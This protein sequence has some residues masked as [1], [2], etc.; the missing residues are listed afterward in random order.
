MKKSYVLIALAVVAALSMVGCKN[1]N[2]KAQSQEAVQEPTQEEVQKMKQAL[3][4]TV[5]AQID[6]FAEEYI[7]ASGNSFTFRGLEL[8][9][10]EKLNKPDYLLDPSV[11]NNLVTKTQKVNALA[12]YLVD[13]GVRM[14]YDMPTEEAKEAITKLAMDVNYPID[15]DH[16]QVGNNLAEVTKSHYEKCKERGELALF[17]Q[18]HNAMIKETYYI[19][20]QNPELFFSKITEEQWQQYIKRTNE[21]NEALRKLAKY[22]EEMAAVLDIFNKTRT[23]SSDEE[24]AKRTASIETHKRY[25]IADK[26]KHIANRNILLQ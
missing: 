9:E 5:L 7:T 14:L 8:T 23:V 4:D 16:M 25:L 22:D 17:W 2:K 24:K 3:T 13:Y 6:A 11:A 10:D 26:D 18:F 21:K 15:T 19:I 1:N 20:V 12:F